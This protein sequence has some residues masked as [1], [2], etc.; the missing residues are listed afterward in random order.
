MTICIAVKINSGL[1]LATD[2]AL[3]FNIQDPKSGAQ[4]PYEIYNNA[5]KIFNLIKGEPIGLMMAGLGEIGS[6]SIESLVKDFRN[7]ISN[8]NNGIGIKKED[9]TVEQIATKFRKFIYDDHYLPHYAKLPEKPDLI[10][11]I[12][13]Y[14]KIKSKIDSFSEIWEIVVSGGTCAPP[15]AVCAPQESGIH[16]RGMVEPIYRLLTGVSPLLDN[17]VLCNAGLDD[18]KRAEILQLCQQKLMVPFVI[19]AMPIQDAID[20][21][22]FLVDMTENYYKFAPYASGVAGPIEIASITKHEGFRW[23]QRKHYFSIDLNRTD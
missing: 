2:S 1:V 9:Y 19:P 10:L 14:S 3:S 21:A 4:I 7:E 5:N 15:R 12:A 13:G 18:K 20:L 8:P 11:F 6:E 16:P 17:E 23:I 22:I